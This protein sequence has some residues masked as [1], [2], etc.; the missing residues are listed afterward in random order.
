MARK[1]EQTTFGRVI[2]GLIK[3]P[4]VLAFLW[5]VLLVIGCFIAW[6]R[7][8]AVHVGQRYYS[9][10]LNQVALTPQPDYI[11]TEVA[12]WVFDATD[13]KSLSLMDV[14]ATAQ[15][16]NAFATSPWVENV[17]RV[18][19]TSDG[20]VDIQV[21]YRRPVAMVEVI[22]DH[23]EVEGLSYFPVDAKGTLLPT[24]D[25]SQ[26]NTKEYIHLV[27]KDSYPIS[28]TG[29]S[30][31]DTRVSDAAG[32]AGILHPLRDRLPISEISVVPRAP[33]EEGPVT[34]V[35]K[36]AN[37]RSVVWG[38]APGKE[39]AGEPSAKEKLQT[40]INN[41]NVKE[42]HLHVAQPPV[43]ARVR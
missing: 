27:I 13:L 15:I 28:D 43:G 26:A 42:L 31:G 1:K 21:I 20:R 14:Q 23:P 3:A 39:L 29:S 25:F 22:S 38:R 12:K 9:L 10:E 37:E 30:Y 36:F 16:A 4:T 33:H 6:Q 35:L 19:K 24:E 40:L 34:L 2:L 18:Q 17:L 5:P 8:G 41:P 7:W 11:Q 32:L